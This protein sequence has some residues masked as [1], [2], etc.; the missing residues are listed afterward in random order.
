MQVCVK[1]TLFAIFFDRLSA[2]YLF[3]LGTAE[4]T[5]RWFHYNSIFEVPGYDHENC[6]K[7][8]WR[9][10]LY[11]NTLFP[12]KEMVNFVKIMRALLLKF[13]SNFQCMLWS[14]YLA[15]DTQFYIVGAILLI[16]ATQ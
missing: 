11:I 2:P 16:L 7:Y 9:N 12:V 14:W 6:P 15:D 10:I 5:M 1:I 8:W 3:V 13:V 4:V